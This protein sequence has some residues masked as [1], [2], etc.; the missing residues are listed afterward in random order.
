MATKPIAC[1]ASPTNPF[2]FSI[3]SRPKKY[4]LVSL[5]AIVPLCL[6]GKIPNPTVFPQ[7]HFHNET[8]NI[9]F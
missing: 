4:L 8:I 3:K 5:P 6:R 2:L 9:Q 1:A 7:N